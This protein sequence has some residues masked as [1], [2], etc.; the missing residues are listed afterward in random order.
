[1]V[2][3]TNDAD[4]NQDNHPKYQKVPS[5][6]H[7]LELLAGFARACLRQPRVST[8][9]P[10]DGYHL[11]PQTRWMKLRRPPVSACQLPTPWGITFYTSEHLSLPD[12]SCSLPARQ[13]KPLDLFHSDPLSS[14]LDIP[15]ELPHCAV[16]S[17]W[18]HLMLVVM[19][20]KPYMPCSSVVITATRVHLHSSVISTFIF[21]LKWS[22]IRKHLP[23]IWNLN[24][25]NTPIFQGGLS[26]CH[27]VRVQRYYLPQPSI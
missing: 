23:F 20:K 8:S 7:F 27:V 14:S 4:G 19:T 6:H 26:R 10:S 13:W 15:D 25:W 3:V 22:W 11:L 12:H 17:K 24:W 2:S 1:M 5:H 9:W 16:L 21:H 18:L